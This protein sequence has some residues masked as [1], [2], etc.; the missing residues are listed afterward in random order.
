MITLPLTCKQIIMTIVGIAT[1]LSILA[2][3]SGTPYMW[4]GFIILI[5]EGIMGAVIGTMYLTEW[6]SENVRCKCK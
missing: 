5:V 3:L 6:L 2:V 1:T 4:G